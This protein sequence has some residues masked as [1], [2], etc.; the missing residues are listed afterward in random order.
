MP[1]GDVVFYRDSDHAYWQEHDEA[2]GTCSGRIPG[3]STV[4]KHD[5]DVNNDPL[6]NWAV[7][8]AYE[9]VANCAAR[10]L[11]SP[12]LT[13]RDLAWLQTGESVEQVLREAGQLWGQV[14]DAK[15]KIGGVSHGVLQALAEG[16]TPMLHTGYDRAV[17]DWWQARQPEPIN[18]EQVTYSKAQGF[19]GRFDLRAKIGKYIAL[20]DAKVSGFISNAYHVQLQGYETANRECGIGPS[21]EQIILQLREDGTWHE[22]PCRATF[23]DFRNAL[24]IYNTG[25]RISSAARKDYK[26]MKPP[27]EQ[28]LAAA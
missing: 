15:G 1:N 5:G 17:V 23:E 3:V 9:G 24:A 20:V 13:R 10:E 27:Q 6:M 26:A 14:R 12:K 11:A 21:D 18:T 25:K 4:S 28:A 2:K 8:L 19:A 16:A 22:W 7:R